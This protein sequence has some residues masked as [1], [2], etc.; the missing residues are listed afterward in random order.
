MSPTTPPPTAAKMSERVTPPDAIARRI[1]AA[2]A[3]VF[4]GSPGGIAWLQ[5]P[6]TWW[7]A[8]TAWSL[9]TKRRPSR[10]WKNPEA[11]RPGPKKTVHWPDVDDPHRGMGRGAEPARAA[12]AGRAGRIVERS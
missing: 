10:G 8:A 12:S 5:S 4:D 11:P 7:N 6:A 9:R 2:W 1:S 3:G